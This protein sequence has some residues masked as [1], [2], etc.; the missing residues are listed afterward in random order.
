MD[1]LISSF[2][3]DAIKRANVNV[4]EAVFIVVFLLIKNIFKLSEI[5]SS[6]T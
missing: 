5:D 4:L 2:L 3:N 6:Q 1:F